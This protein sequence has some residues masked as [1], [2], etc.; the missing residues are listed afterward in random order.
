MN[1][2]VG[3]SIVFVSMHQFY[4]FGDAKG[5]APTA[6]AAAVAGSSAPPGG[7]LGAGGVAIEANGSAWPKMLHSPSME[8]FRV[9]GGPGES[10]GA[11]APVAEDIEL[12]GKGA[13][14]P[15]LPR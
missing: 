1:F 2:V 12:G 7:A 4:T 6:A 10:S 14:A 13:R 8:H 3:V 15:L 5:S 11:L 9:Q